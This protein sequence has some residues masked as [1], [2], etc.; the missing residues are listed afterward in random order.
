M[1]TWMKERIT[2]VFMR[3]VEQ[4]WRIFKIWPEGY[5]FF[6][7]ALKESSFVPFPCLCTFSRAAQLASNH[8]PW[9]RSDRAHWICDG[10]SLSPNLHGLFSVPLSVLFA[11]HHCYKSFRVRQIIPLGN[12][13]MLGRY[14]AHMWYACSRPWRILRRLGGIEVITKR[15][16]MYS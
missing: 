4:R 16:K 5:D 10:T 8:M 6:E 15:D 14:Q 1:A 13:V 11:V 3:P 7:S 9:M 2:P 12:A